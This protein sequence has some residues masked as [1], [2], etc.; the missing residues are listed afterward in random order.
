MFPLVEVEDGRTW[1]VPMKPKDDPVG[2]CLRRQ[3]RFKHLTEEQLAEIRRQVYTRWDA[4]ERR[5]L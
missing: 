5:A 2:P 4:L 1:R 3:D